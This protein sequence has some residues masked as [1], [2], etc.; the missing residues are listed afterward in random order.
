M[1][2]TFQYECVECGDQEC[3]STAELKETQDGPPMTTCKSCDSTICR[4]CQHKHSC[5][6]PDGNGG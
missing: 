6:I 2:L 5:F 4:D 3:W 1:P